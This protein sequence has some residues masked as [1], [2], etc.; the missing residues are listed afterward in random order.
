VG[1]SLF[2]IIDLT[3]DDRSA[4]L[5]CSNK[6]QTGLNSSNLI[7]LLP[8]STMV[9]ELSTYLLENTLLLA[10]EQIQANHCLEEDVD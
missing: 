9:L 2:Q 6:Q 7:H 10:L 1:L 3:S 4:N 8:R 5:V